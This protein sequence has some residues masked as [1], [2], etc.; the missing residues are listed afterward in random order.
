MGGETAI[1]NAGNLTLNNLGGTR[2][3]NVHDALEAMNNKIDQLGGGSSSHFTALRRPQCPGNYNN[4]GATGLDAWQ[5][6]RMP[7]LRA[8][9]P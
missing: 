2:Q 8:I 9:L 5:Q 7:K 6:A 1:D 3:T 4:D